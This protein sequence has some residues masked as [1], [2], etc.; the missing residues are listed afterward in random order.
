MNFDVKSMEGILSNIE[1]KVSHADF[2]SKMREL[3]L[4]TSN[5]WNKTLDLLI[6]LLNSK[7]ITTIQKSSFIEAIK[8][9]EQYLLSFSKAIFIYKLNKVTHGSAAVAERSFI[10]NLKN[11]LVRDIHP[12]IFPGLLSKT[13]MGKYSGSPIIRKVRSN[14]PD[15]YVF[16]QV[17]EYTTQDEIPI[18]K[19]DTNAVNKLK[20][21]TKIFGVKTVSHEHVDSIYFDK[22]NNQIILRL[23]ITKPGTTILNTQE[24]LSRRKIYE[25]ILN[26]TVSLSISAFSL[27]DPSNFFNAIE[28]IYSSPTEG[29]IC[30]LGFTTTI[31]GAIKQERM[32]RMG[33]DLR[34]EPW[35]VGGMTAISKGPNP[36]TVDMY[37]LS[38]TWAIRHSTDQPVLTIPGTYKSLEK[39]EISYAIILGCKE[40]TSFDFALQR[41]LAHS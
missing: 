28:N 38:V 35:H 5:S 36:D 27:P 30:E 24:I 10:S 34:T 15:L 33:V 13:D 41:L 14:G 2:T 1:R 23:D 7:S 9:I 6:T 22:K 12:S 37:R 31:G 21:Y 26:K 8:W 4:P 29:S 18:T 40:N 20:G 39:E 25:D 11:T 17:K 19:S 3:S 16:S 32:K